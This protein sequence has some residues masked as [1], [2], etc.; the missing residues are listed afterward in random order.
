MAA[1]IVAGQSTAGGNVGT[2]LAYQTATVRTEV[3]DAWALVSTAIGAGLDV[4]GES[5]GCSAELNVSAITA[6]KAWVRWGI[7][8]SMN[9]GGTAPGSAEVTLTVA[10]VAK[11]MMIG[12]WSGHLTSSTTSDTNIPVT[13]WVPAIWAQTVFVALLVTSAAANF[14]L[15]LI[16]R[17]AGASKESPGNWANTTD[18]NN[19]G[20]QTR[21]I[22]D[23][24]L[25]PGSN[26]WVQFGLAYSSSSGTAG[27]E[28][29][30]SVG[31]R[32]D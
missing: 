19:S 17:V 15:R 28:V 1:L 23:A 18:T 21:G 4:V 31:V 20:N 11:G 14:R 25:A 29:S 13:G 7:G 10:G 22:S 24:T 12:T 8:F 6:D 27:G 2:Q 16:V 32:R 5:T 9:T 30:I 3:P 26:L